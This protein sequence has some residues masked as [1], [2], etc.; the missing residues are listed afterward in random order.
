MAYRTWLTTPPGQAP[1]DEDVEPATERYSPGLA[2]PME[3][4]VPA[5]Y[6][7][8]AIGTI[9]VLVLLVLAGA[10]FQL[11]TSGQGFDPSLTQTVDEQPVPSPSA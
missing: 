5:R 7:G 9:V 8:V 4:W 3:P 1:A 10:A 6:R 11:V 2:E